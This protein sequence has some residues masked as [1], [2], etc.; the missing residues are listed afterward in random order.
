MREIVLNTNLEIIVVQ[1]DRA[2]S[3]RVVTRHVLPR[4]VVRVPENRAQRGSIET[5]TWGK[6][7]NQV[8]S[9][10]AG[11]EVLIR[12]PWNGTIDVVPP[13]AKD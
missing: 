4:S 10:K 13:I 9:M 3:A 7:R 2:R 6:I 12:E 1:L 8:I 11:A 5:Q